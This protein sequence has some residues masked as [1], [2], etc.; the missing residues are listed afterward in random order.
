MSKTY[1]YKLNPEDVPEPHSRD[2]FTKQLRRKAL[3]ELEQQHQDATTVSDQ[4]P[5]EWEDGQ[6]TDAD[7]MARKYG[8]SV[9]LFTSEVLGGGHSLMAASLARYFYSIGYRVASVGGLL[10]GDR[11]AGALEEYSIL[12]FPPSNTILL[13][14]A[15]F[16]Y[17]R[18]LAYHAVPWEAMMSK[19][20][21]NGGGII[22]DTGTPLPAPTKRLISQA[23]YCYR[24]LDRAE[25]LRKGGR[26]HGIASSMWPLRALEIGPMPFRDSLV[27]SA[28]G[29]LVT[30]TTL[31]ALEKQPWA[32]R[33]LVDAAKCYDAFA[34]VSPD[35]SGQS[36]PQDRDVQVI[37]DTDQ[38]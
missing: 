1:A 29:D 33:D 27:G 9:T 26:L 20:L 12:Q 32:P 8:N 23:V 15:G 16:T 38:E 37:H 19:F 28:W 25:E 31:P 3:E 30:G 18:H 10:F 17:R 13:I 21:E 34:F 6:S 5:F 22:V 24:D 14:D 36:M 7:L 4:P 11:L 2:W 35:Y